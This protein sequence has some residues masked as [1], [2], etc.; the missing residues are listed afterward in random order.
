MTLTLLSYN[1]RYGGVDK[2]AEL[3]E[4]IRTVAPDVVLLQEATHPAI[5]A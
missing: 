5:V 1:I 2:Q 4:V 3:A